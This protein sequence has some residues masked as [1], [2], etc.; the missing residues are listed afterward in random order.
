MQCHMWKGWFWI[1][2]FLHIFSYT[3]IELNNSAT[4]SA[5]DNS[6]AGTENSKPAW[7][8]FT[9]ANLSK[10]AWGVLE[11]VYRFINRWWILISHSI[12]YSD[13]FKCVSKVS[14]SAKQIIWLLIC[15]HILDF[16]IMG[17][18]YKYSQMQKFK[19]RF[20]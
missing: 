9:S 8:L 15:L 4:S 6:Q 20:I 3:G 14:I 7:V 1:S 18:K 16:K 10:S 19:K 5:V 11:K 13:K 17:L 12:K 2:I